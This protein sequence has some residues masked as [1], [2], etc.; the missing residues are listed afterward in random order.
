M[1]CTT[2]ATTVVIADATDPPTRVFVVVYMGGHVLCPETSLCCQCVHQLCRPPMTTFSLFS[3]IAC[4]MLQK[5]LLDVIV[6]SFGSQSYGKAMDCLKALRKESI[7]V[8]LL[9]HESVSRFTFCSP[10]GVK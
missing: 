10:R 1:H 7:K 3:V 8:S 9:S 4:K 2:E 6:N 5:V